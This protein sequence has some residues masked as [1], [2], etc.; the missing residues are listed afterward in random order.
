ML[1]G[2]AHQGGSAVTIRAALLATL[3]ILAPF[4]ARAADLVVWWD[5][6]FHPEQDQALAEL[7]RA[8]EAKTGL[9][10]EFVRHDLWDVPKEIEVAIAAGR[11]PDFMFAH[12]QTQGQLER[13]AAEDRL[14]DLSNVVGGLLDLFDPDLIDLSM[15]VNSRTGSRGLYALPMGRDTNHIHVWLSLLE[16][17]GFR[18]EDI[19]T[20]WEPFWSFWCGRVQPAVR[21]A[22]GREDVWAVGAPMSLGATDTDH[23]V[24]SFVYAYTEA[25]P[26][27]TGPSL[28]RDPAARTALVKGLTGYTAIWKKACTPPDSLGWT[29]LGNNEA[30]LAQRVVMTINDTLTI[31]NMLKF[32]RPDDYYRN[33]ITIGWPKDAFGRPEHIEGGYFKAGVF[34]DGG[35]T[36]AAEELVRFLVGD[37]GLVQY[38]TE[39]GDGLL[40]PSR[41]MLDQPFWLDPRDPHRLRAAVQAM[42]EPHLWLAYGLD[43][44]QQVRLERIGQFTA[45]STAVHRI[46]A[47]GLTPEQAADEA[48]ARVKQL[49]GK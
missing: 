45:Y 7:T 6:A 47:D 18:R 33:A 40:S 27:P 5:K 39:G 38:L 8:F 31:P 35:H 1:A 15:A 2:E 24:R 29:N 41:R 48:I 10:I 19:P 43:R 34:K 49:L 42:S 12:Q 44:A 16:R 13:W 20:E 30:F 28:T 25:W 26:T 37:G 32:S 3:L 46:A 23:G 14:V 36:Q 4:G 22:L 21:K 9:K 11:P 17:A